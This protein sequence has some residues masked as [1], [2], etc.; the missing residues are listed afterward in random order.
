[1]IGITINPRKSA[2]G[3]TMVVISPNEGK[4]AADENERMN[5]MVEGQG[6]DP[7]RGSIK[8][9]KYVIFLDGLS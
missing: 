7:D 6:L 8:F 3:N 1:M 2:N 5:V 9:F 4:R